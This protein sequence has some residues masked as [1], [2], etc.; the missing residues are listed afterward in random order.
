MKAYSVSPFKKNWATNVSAFDGGNDQKLSQSCRQ[1]D[2]ERHQQSSMDTCKI[3]S[4]TVNYPTATK[5]KVS[6]VSTYSTMSTFL[7]AAH[8]A[9]EDRAVQAIG[10][11]LVAQS[12]RS[13]KWFRPLG[14]SRRLPTLPI[15]REVVKSGDADPFTSD[16]DK[17][18]Y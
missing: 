11:S 14:R 6:G 5:K 1:G 17:D 8:V 7:Q 16:D 2:E 10:S 12:R 13:E 9:L 15:P 18:S 3:T 4:P